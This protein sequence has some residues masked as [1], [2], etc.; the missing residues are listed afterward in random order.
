MGAI[1]VNPQIHGR[2]RQK[3]KSYGSG[4]G[5]GTRAMNPSDGDSGA[6]K[7]RMWVSIPNLKG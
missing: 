5:G 1:R 7:A 6:K 2:Q 4:G 3:N